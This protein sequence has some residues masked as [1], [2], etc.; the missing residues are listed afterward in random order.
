[1]NSPLS[2]V[3]STAANSNVLRIIV[4]YFRLSNSAGTANPEVRLGVAS[5]NVGPPVTTVNWYSPR[6]LERLPAPEMPR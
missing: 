2:M 6:R 5:R 1:M 3:V 4:T